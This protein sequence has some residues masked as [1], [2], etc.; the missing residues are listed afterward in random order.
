MKNLL[1]KFRNWLLK[2]NN[3]NYYASNN[4]YFFDYLIKFEKEKINENKADSFI[5]GYINKYDLLKKR[6]EEFDDS[7]LNK[8]IKILK[9]EIESLKHISKVLPF[10]TA[11]YA[12][13]VS[14][15]TKMFNG[16]SLFVYLIIFAVA[17][18]V[19]MVDLKKDSKIIEYNLL[20]IDIISEILKERNE[21]SNS[22]LD[23]ID[24][25]KHID[26]KQ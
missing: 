22:E 10:E 4:D 12:I 20:S 6:L 26:T 16:G 11:F 9:N 8:L 21:K 3:A 5:D 15:I 7:Q 14:L 18:I 1:S 24:T 13:L 23:N 2:K 25:E 19:E 17:F